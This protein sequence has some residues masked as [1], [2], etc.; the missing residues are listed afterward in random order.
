MNYVREGE[1]DMH[2][3]KLFSKWELQSSRRPEGDSDPPREGL[4]LLACLK[5]QAT[6]WLLK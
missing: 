1:S 5:S 3:D 2:A 4:M 6:L